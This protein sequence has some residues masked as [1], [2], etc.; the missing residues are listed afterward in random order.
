VKLNE[1]ITV[2]YRSENGPIIRQFTYVGADVVVDDEGD[3]YELITDILLDD[4]FLSLE[5][6]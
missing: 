3:E 4:D 2:T 1:L 5:R 6:D